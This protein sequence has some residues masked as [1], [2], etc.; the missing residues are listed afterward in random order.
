MCNNGLMAES[1]LEQGGS[2]EPA[3]LTPLLAKLAVTAD[4]A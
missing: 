3:L 2:I 4:E 1:G